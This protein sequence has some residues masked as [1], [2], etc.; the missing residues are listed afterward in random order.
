MSRPDREYFSTSAERLA[1]RLLGASLVRVFA[2]GV[3]VSG[4]IVET[5]AYCGFPDRGS[6]AYGGR[7]TARNESMYAG[8]GIAYVYFTYGMHYCVNVVCGMAGRPLAVLLRAI[9]PVEGLERMR[10]LRG[11]GRTGA[12]Q[13]SERDLCSGPGKLCQALGIDRKLD[14]ID[15]VESEELF[16]ELPAVGRRG[17]GPGLGRIRRTARI[18][19]GNAGEWTHRPLRWLLWGNPFVSPAR[20][21]ASKVAGG[22]RG[23]VR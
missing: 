15:L 19:L 16:L 12:R 2:D 22:G 23:K 3:R 10:E 8:P 17:E 5:E 6:H 13:R 1:R 14:G 4:R 9:E 21:P 11:G 20:A 7:R 18:G